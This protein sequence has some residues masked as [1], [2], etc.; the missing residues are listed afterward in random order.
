MVVLF[1]D[2]TFLPSKFNLLV[3]SVFIVWLTTLCFLQ[4]RF[5]WSSKLGGERMQRRRRRGRRGAH[6]SAAE[7]TW[8]VSLWVC[9]FFSLCISCERDL[10]SQFT[11]PFYNLSFFRCYFCTCNCLGECRLLVGWWM[12][13]TAFLTSNLTV[14]LSLTHS[15]HLICQ[16]IKWKKSDDIEFMAHTERRGKKIL[17]SFGELFRRL[18]LV[19]LKG[20]WKVKRNWKLNDEKGTWMTSQFQDKIHL[21]SMGE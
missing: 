6:F 13:H 11:G 7:T 9:L 3:V 16:W 15:L 18:R 12:E 21:A 4:Q 20:E 2:D 17:W 8:V 5:Y 10:V 19:G 1:V 14:N